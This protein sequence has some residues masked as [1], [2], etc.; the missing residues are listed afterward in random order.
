MIWN[1]ETWLCE[2]D[3]CR[4]VNAAF[5]KRCRSCNAP[6]PGPVHPDPEINA[7]IQ[8]EMQE[9]AAFDARLGLR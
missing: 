1:G 6:H 5:R 7:A 4:F 9:N 2:S 3:R 8:R